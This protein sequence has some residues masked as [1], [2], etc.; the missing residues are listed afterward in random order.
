MSET[1]EIVRFYIQW[2]FA[3]P[4]SESDVQHHQLGSPPPGYGLPAYTP[5]E[6]QPTRCGGTEA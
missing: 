6:P 1:S 4:P 2:P 3:I 5:T